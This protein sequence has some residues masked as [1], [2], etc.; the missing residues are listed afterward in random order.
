VDDEIERWC[1]DRNWLARDTVVVYTAT[2][3]EHGSTAV[4]EE[5]VYER[6]SPLIE[7]AGRWKGGQRRAG[8]CSTVD[9]SDAAGL[10]EP[11]R[12]TIGMARR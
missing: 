8:A 12:P 1:V 5:L 4:V 9:P 7:R 2:M 6:A 3:A 11:A 10:G